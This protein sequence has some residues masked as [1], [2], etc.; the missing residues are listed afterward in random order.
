MQKV[1][2]I[3][4]IFFKAKDKKGLIAW[5][6]KNLGVP[7][8]PHGSGEFPWRDADGGEHMTVWSVFPADS[9]Y[10][11]GSA[12]VNYLVDDLDAMLEQLK[13][14]GADIDPKRQGD[15]Q[16]GRFAWVTDPEGNRI[17]LWEPPKE[18]K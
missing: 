3:G 11:G 4:G 2:G 7:I 16:F 18:K 8:Q 17:E 15:D 14:A 5:Y 10:F 12:M 9:K 13:A 6:E 1:K